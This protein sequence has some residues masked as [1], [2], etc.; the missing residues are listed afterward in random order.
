METK[1]NLPVLQQQAAPAVQQVAALVIATPKDMEHAGELR[2][3]LKKV[4]KAVK[5]DKEKITKPLNE[6]LKQVR[7][8]YAGIEE[9]VD[10]ALTGLN[11]KMTVYQTIE[12]AK[13]NAA[14][15]KIAERTAKGQLRPETAVRKLGEIDK[16]ADTLSSATGFMSVKKFEVVDFV[17]LSN[18][19]KIADDAKIRQAMR[20]GIEI[21]GVRYYTEQ[22]PKSGR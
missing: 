5:L 9:I 11:K 4:E 17:E 7:A 16:P 14:A 15:A 1:D 13:A 6:A 18:D 12:V 2:E 21:K 19:Y 22:V 3:S 10:T 8:K 20:E